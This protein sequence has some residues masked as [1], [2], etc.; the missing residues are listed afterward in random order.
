MRKYLLI[1][2]HLIVLIWEI[3]ILVLFKLITDYKF[4][5]GLSILFILLILIFPLIIYIWSY[6]QIKIIKIRHQLKVKG[7]YERIKRDLMKGN[8][9]P[10]LLDKINKLGYTTNIQEESNTIN[11]LIYKDNKEIM[12]IEF[13]KQNAK[14][15]ILKTLV[16]YRFYYSY[17][18][19]EF[20]K[21]DLRNFEYK[22][23]DVL[24]D[25]IYKIINR[26]SNNKYIYIQKSHL[27]KLTRMDNKE[28]IYQRKIPIAYRNKID[29]MK[30]DI[31]I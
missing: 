23:T 25:N 31:E 19:G 26:L 24:Y 10:N 14:L 12:L 9:Y 4:S 28:E 18:T 20:T 21:Y 17:V 5:K 16:I 8:I 22:E 7:Y 2:R 3:I 13:T 6:I 11:V 29:K 1:Y 30:V 15:T 27:I